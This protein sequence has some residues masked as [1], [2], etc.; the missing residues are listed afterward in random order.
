VEAGGDPLDDTEA[1]PAET[2]DGPPPHISVAFPPQTSLH[3]ISLT[4]PFGGRLPDNDLLHQHALLCCM[5]AILKPCAAH[6]AVHDSIVAG[7]ESS[8]EVLSNE[9]PF[10][11]LV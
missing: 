2:L 9:T 3:I 5:P 6:A 8:T 7:C 4:L 10:S 11:V 1:P